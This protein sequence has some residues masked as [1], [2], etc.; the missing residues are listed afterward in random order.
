MIG[1]AG[2]GAL[3]EGKIPLRELNWSLPLTISSRIV[4]LATTS[5]NAF[6]SD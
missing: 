3:D 5:N 2:R 1:M 4:F 6:R